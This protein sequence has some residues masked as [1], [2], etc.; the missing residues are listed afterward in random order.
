MDRTALSGRTV[1]ML[2]ALGLLLAIVPTIAAGF[3]MCGVSGCSG[4]GFGRSTDPGATRLLLVS[5]GVVAALPVALHALVRR[6]AGLALASAGLA[7]LATLVAGL[8]VGSDLRGC[9]RDVDAAT[10]HDESR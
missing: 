4:G 9:P 10:C 3:M 2:V 6:H 5:A 7:V 1:A 8:V